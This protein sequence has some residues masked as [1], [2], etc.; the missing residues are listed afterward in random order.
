MNTVFGGHRSPPSPT[1]QAVYTTGRGK[2]G[3]TISFL[4]ENYEG[5]DQ[6]HTEVLVITLDVGENELKRILV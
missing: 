4:D 1:E 3:A 6:D 2:K 5:I